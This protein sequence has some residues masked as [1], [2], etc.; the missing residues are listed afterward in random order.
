[1]GDTGISRVEALVASLGRFAGRDLDLDESV[2]V[3][4]RDT[5]HRNR[6]IA[7]LLRGTGA[8]AADPDGV[9]D[10][11]FKVC[12]VSV[13]ARDLAL[14]AATLANGGRH[15][16]TGELAASDATVRDTLSVMATCGMYDGAGAWV[17]RLEARLAAPGT[18]D[19]LV[20]VG[21]MHRLGNDGVVEKLRRKGYKV[22]RICSA[23][24]GK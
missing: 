16:L 24:S 11:Y 3:S 9:V 15:P 6:A 7:H 12:A 21:A 22:E 2:Y 13:T 23:C 1:M 5:G 4:E 8:I 18:D 14:V 20:V 17:P 10:A 19:T